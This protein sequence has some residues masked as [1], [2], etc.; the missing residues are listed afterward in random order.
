MAGSDT[1][2]QA[3]NFWRC[4]RCGTPNPTAN[5]LTTCLGCG[6]RPVT[7]QAVTVD[8]SPANAAQP[9]TRFILSDI[10]DRLSWAYAILVLAV[11][12]VMWSLG[13]RWWPATL[14]LFMPRIL[15]LL[16]LGLLAITTFLAGSHRGRSWLLQGTTATIVIGPLMGLHVP[17]R[18]WT[19]ERESGASLRVMTFNRAG[20]SV[21]A[22]GLAA[23]LDR[24]QVD[25]VCFQETGR[26]GVDPA[27]LPGWSKNQDG[28]IYTRYPV[29]KS[30][31]SSD[32]GGYPEIGFWPVRHSRLSIRHPSGVDVV[33]VSGHMPTPRSGMN[34]YL[35]GARTAAARYLEWR[36]KQIG[37]LGAV[38]AETADQPTILGA[39]LNTTTDSP[40][41]GLLRVGYRD[42]FEQA[43]WGYG[44]TRPAN[45]PWVG[46]D[47]IL[48]SGS[49]FVQRCWVGPDLGSD[50]RPVVAD[51]ALRVEAG[52][53]R[54]DHANQ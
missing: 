4:D 26:E 17:M 42:A 16:P 37:V 5:Y 13:D 6:T 48:V 34:L 27:F 47:H 7:R 11:L 44:Y 38:L 23:Y 33:I 14:I 10:V 53:Q 31:E 54:A 9:S 46:I 36:W 52:P 12:A 50:H 49:C 1:S 8:V 19:G 43:G 51:I 2:P 22:A 30:W 40:L 32:L 21:D 45:L 3:N 18:N 15:W 29:A 28:S 25:I 24:E 41:F 39:D 35:G 20:T